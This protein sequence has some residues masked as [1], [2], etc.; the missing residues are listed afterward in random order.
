MADKYNIN[1]FFAVI[2]AILSLA[3]IASFVAEWTE[4]IQPCTICNLQRVG[5]SLMALVSFAA[6]FFKAKRTFGLMIIFFSV[7]SMALACYHIGIQLGVFTNFCS[8]VAPTQIH[9]FKN[10]LFHSQPSCSSIHKILGVP[11]S[12]LNLLASLA[13]FA[14]MV[15]AI[16]SPQNI[17][18]QGGKRC[19]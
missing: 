17:K 8:V 13:C 10:M 2:C 16:R 7:L 18:Y 19:I 11:I 6:I 15:C 12:G 9:D 5:Y 14:I 1:Y 3:L 4:K